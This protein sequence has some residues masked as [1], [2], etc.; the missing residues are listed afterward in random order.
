MK[1]SLISGT[2]AAISSSRRRAMISAGR[3]AQ[4]TSTTS[5]GVMPVPAEMKSIRPPSS[6]S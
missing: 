6:G 4:L 5:D 1:C 3:R 2:R